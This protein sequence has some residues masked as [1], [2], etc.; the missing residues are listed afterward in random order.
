MSTIRVTLLTLVLLQPQC[1]GS[2][3]TQQLSLV[4]ELNSKGPSTQS[5]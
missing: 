3:A 5:Y 1:T 2:E 4:M